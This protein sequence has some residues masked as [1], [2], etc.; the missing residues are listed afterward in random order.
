VCAARRTTA[1]TTC[2]HLPTANSLLCPF[3]GGSEPSRSIF[4]LSSAFI[5]RAL[6]LSSRSPLLRLCSRHSAERKISCIDRRWLSSSFHSVPLPVLRALR[7]SPHQLYAR[8]VDSTA[9]SP[10]HY[11]ALHS[12]LTNTRPIPSAFFGT[13]PHSAHCSIY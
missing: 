10:L 3:C 5:E 7:T 2:E 1:R 9:H 12:Q 4:P 6:L 8:T 11:R 13:V